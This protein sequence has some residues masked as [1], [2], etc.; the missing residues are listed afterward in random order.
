MREDIHDHLSHLPKIATGGS[1]VGKSIRLHT[2]VVKNVLEEY[3]YIMMNALP[4]Y[5]DP[6][7]HTHIAFVTSEHSLLKWLLFLEKTSGKSITPLILHQIARLHKTL[8][9]LKKHL[10]KK[11]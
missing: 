5:I 7:F 3:H 4:G 9:R 8:K 10:E 1:D 11:H 6:V 2:E